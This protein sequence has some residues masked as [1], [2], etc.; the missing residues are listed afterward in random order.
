MVRAGG[1]RPATRPD[2]PG[3]RRARTG[4]AFIPAGGI[5]RGAPRR[6]SAGKAIVLVV[7]CDIG[8]GPNSGTAD[9]CAPV[10]GHCGP[11]PDW[12]A[13]HR[14]GDGGQSKYRRLC[15]GSGFTKRRRA[16]SQGGPPTPSAGKSSATPSFRAPVRCC[17][18]AEVG[19]I[20]HGRARISSAPAIP[21]S[22]QVRL[23]VEKVRDGIGSKPILIRERRGWLFRNRERSASADS[24]FPNGC[25][26][27]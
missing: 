17:W 25:A 9:P 23:T 26:A 16:W 7:L 21:P 5:A 6:S 4:I 27:H 22:T 2:D 10:P 12:A 14:A 8:S 13:A 15:V 18:H 11:K 3:L 19:S 1:R 20:R 24:A